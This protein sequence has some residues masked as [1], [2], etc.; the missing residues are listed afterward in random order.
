MNDRAARFVVVGGWVLA[1]VA[2]C[3]SL[4]SVGP[5]YERPEF[6]VPKYDMPDAGQPTS[7]LTATCEYS[8]A[9]D[10]ED[11]RLEITKGVVDQWWRRFNDPVLNRLVE[12]G[13]SNNV[14]Y[15]RAKMRLEQAN[16]ELLG[17][18]AAFRP[19]FVGAG[20]WGRNWYHK[21]TSGGGGNRTHYNAQ[22]VALDGQWELDI[23]GGNRRLSE[24]AFA[25]A[26][27]AGWTLDDAWV[28]L[29]MQIGIQY[30][31][32]RTTQ[33][34]IGAV[35]LLGRQTPMEKI[36]IDFSVV[37]DM[38]YYNGIVFKGFLGGICDGV[39]AGGQ[40]D[41]LMQKMGRKSGAVGFALYLDLL[42][43]LKTR[44]S[45]YDAEVLLLYTD[46]TDRALVAE[47]AEELVKAGRS[48]N[49]QKSIPPH[50]RYKEIIKI[51]EEG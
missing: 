20:D 17:S 10:T 12:G 3:S 40:Y 6:A 35:E 38:N 42:E 28:S 39:L 2:G 33:E 1:L 13:V 25:E 51:G 48:V 50:M 34:L 24:V 14:G 22:S 32:L 9:K 37:N 41:K 15:L 30:I 49:V 21:F 31:N 44:K 19:H 18:Y 26:E 5:D 46:E 29:T 45:S 7:N 36:R 23:F 43:Q 8:P 27:A 47:K 16:W 4:P 11:Q